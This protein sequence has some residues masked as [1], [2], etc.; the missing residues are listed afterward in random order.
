MKNKFSISDFVDVVTE[1]SVKHDIAQRFKERRKESKMTQ[2]ELSKQSGISYASIR[3]F[4]TK[5]DISLHALLR[6]SSVIGCLEDFNNLFN[7]P[8]VKDI[9]Q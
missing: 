8:I 7:H 1:Q 4:E 2:K 3:R 9:R 5:G 6:L